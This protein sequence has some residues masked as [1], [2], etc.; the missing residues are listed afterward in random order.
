MNETLSGATPAALGAYER[1]LADLRCYAGDP[2]AHCEEALAHA[3]AMPMAHALKAY[4]HLIGTEPAGAA[5]ALA[6]CDAGEPQA[7]T[8]A[9]RAHLRA[10]RLL[11]AGHWYAAGR[12]LEDISLAQPRDLL[13]LQVGHQVDY[14]T[15]DARMLRDR[16][17]RVLP[18]WSRE[19]AGYHAVLSMY[20]FGLE[21][22]G[23]YARAEQMGRA[24]V[25]LEPRDGW[26]WHAVAHVMEMRNAPEAGIAW[27]RPNAE[28]WSAGSG[29]A[30]HNWW[31]LALFH[32]ELGEVDEVLRL[33]D[34]AIGGPG[35][36]VVLDMIDQS[37]MLWRLQLRGIDVGDRWTALAGRWAAVAQPGLYA[38][39]DMHAM[40]AFAGA[41]DRHGQQAILDAQAGA[42]QREGDNA[43]FAREVG[44]PAVRAVQAFAD[45]D[46][47]RAADLLRGIRSR[48]Q[49][50]GGSHAQRDV[51]D[52]TLI[53][54][55]RLARDDALMR[56]LAW[57]RACLRPHA[58]LDAGAIAS[59]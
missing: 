53:A 52:L 25:E 3:P 28:T 46:F 1:A 2:L 39:N 43:L 42:M 5:V 19:D 8:G 59:S 35:S 54:A 6:T 56:A 47:S 7:R 23:D 41:G 34:A 48:A 22:T 40:M 13:A 18:H 58:A 15:G 31:H 45:G 10:A 20:A 51:I 30:V 12:V 26:G 24:A 33:Y 14:F 9:E 21:E 32:L 57:E 16:V 29:L 55:A 49:R 36:Q 38:F 17:A 50:F 11:A 37:A 44:A 27:L 4:L